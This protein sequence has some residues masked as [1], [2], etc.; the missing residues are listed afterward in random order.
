MTFKSALSFIGLLKRLLGDPLL[1]TSWYRY[2]GFC[3][4]SVACLL[5]RVSYV[6]PLCY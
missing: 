1:V 3:S 5:V 2:V 6:L 4:L